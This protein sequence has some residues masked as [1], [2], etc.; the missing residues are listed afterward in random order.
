M[1]PP[2]RKAETQPQSMP[3]GVWLLPVPPPL[4]E[5]WGVEP[6]DRVFLF[7]DPLCPKL[8][9]RL[10]EQGGNE[11]QEEPPCDDL[12]CVFRKLL[13]AIGLGAEVAEEPSPS[14]EPSKMECELQLGSFT[15]RLT[16]GWKSSACPKSE[17]PAGEKSK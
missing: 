3:P 17:E 6:M 9:V 10:E 4:V 14:P 13:T 5:P 1:I 16:F 2:P 8:A 11:E 7:V 15:F 12:G